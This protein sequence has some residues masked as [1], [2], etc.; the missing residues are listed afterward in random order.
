MH[1]PESEIPGT[2]S[3][4]EASNWTTS[5]ADFELLVREQGPRMLSVIRRY[6]RND[7]DAQDAL[8]DA[9]LQAYRHAKQF[10][11]ESSSATWLHTVACRAAL[12]KLRSTRRF[13]ETGELERL[14]PAY[15]PDG[16]RL[17][18]C[19]DWP[20]GPEETA[21]RREVRAIVREAID[22]LPEPFRSVLMLRDIDGLSTLETSEC[23][24]INE[25]AVKTR[26]HRARQALR[27]L[28]ARKLSA[29]RN[30]GGLP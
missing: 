6:L 27:T 4:A 28:I 5:R 18:G 13:A 10:R 15:E 1:L 19:A 24:G 17:P 20:E 23:M 22:E 26:L 2:S 7:A 21:S 8:Q 16:H 3:G 12:M 29:C 9:F 25:G 14:V 30:S 11:G